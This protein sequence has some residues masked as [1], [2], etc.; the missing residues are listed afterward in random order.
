MSGARVLA[1]V[2]LVSLRAGAA[3]AQTAPAAAFVGRPVAS[4]HIL[5]EGALVTDTQVLSVL[6]TPVGGA[7]SMAAVRESIAH[8]FSLGRFQDVHVDAALEAGGVALRYNLIPVHGVDRVIFRGT[9]G[10][11]ER[12][13][14]R[15]LTERY[16]AVPPVGRGAD[17]ARLL[18]DLYADH[19]YLRAG[20]VPSSQVRHDPDRT[21]LVFDV[22]PGPRA[23]VRNVEIQGVPMD[24]RVALLDELNLGP[25]Q[26]YEA[27]VL[28]RELAEYAL[29][30]RGRGYYESAATHAIHPTRDGAAVDVML[31]IHPGPLVALSFE[32]DPLPS[33]QIDELVPVRREGSV[34]ADLLEDS[35]RRIERFLHQQGYWKA[36]VTH[37]R[38]EGQGRTT[39]VL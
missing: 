10:L 9:L 21:T 7:L 4:V 1:A 11:P 32:G 14:R 27:P 15:T 25:G 29:A 18:Q 22:R 34:D 37:R 3:L 26:H 35:E 38:T 13:L 5:Q 16:G 28:E 12:T 6:E 23:L 31:E 36:D 17:A 24:T 30:L 20:I 33:G 19:G 2:V 39:I 8:L